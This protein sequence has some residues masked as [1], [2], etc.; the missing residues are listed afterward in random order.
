AAASADC[1][2]ANRRLATARR[3][4]GRPIC[5]SPSARAPRHIPRHRFARRSLDGPRPTAD[6]QTPC[7]PPPRARAPAAACRRK[8][9]GV[10]RRE[11][12]E[13]PERAFRGWKAY[14]LP[15]A[16][17]MAIRTEPSVRRHRHAAWMGLALR[18]RGRS[19]NEREREVLKTH[20]Y[21]P[22]F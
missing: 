7:A 8:K 11:A 20:L 14:R 16:A 19:K 15:D 3:Y 22:N 18:Q 4:R 5:S 9:T 10:A 6:R 21:T 2:A 1:L 17:V 13:R 12:F